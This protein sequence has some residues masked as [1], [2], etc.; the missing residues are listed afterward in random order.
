MQCNILIVDD[1][2]DIL[3]LLHSTIDTFKNDDIKIFESQS[4]EEAMLESS[5]HRVD[6]L[7][8]DYKLPGMTGV[9]LMHKIR[10]RHPEAKVIMISGETERKVRNEMLNAGA[11]AIFEKPIPLAEFLD[12]V[13][14][15]LG[16]VQTMF[17]PEKEA[18]EEKVE[19]RHVKLSDLLVNFRQDI[20][21]EAVLMLN[22]MG[23]VHA[24]TGALRDES[25][26]TAIVAV[27]M[28]I[29]NAS[30]KVARYTRQETLGSYH[31]FSGGDY[32]LL[33]TPINTM[34]AL[35]VVGKDIAAKDR[36]VENVGNMVALRDEVE[37][38]LKSIGMTG[39]TL[40]DVKKATSP[41]AGPVSASA[42]VPTMRL[43]KPAEVAP[44]PEMEALL[45]GAAEKKAP[46]PV[47]DADDFWNQ[48]AETH[49]KK[50]ANS[51]VMSLEEARKQ[52]LIPDDKK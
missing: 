29:H 24:R 48:A 7:I 47:S 4:G 51:N 12:V 18:T 31:V 27:L 36:I 30:L 23:F 2:R 38:S 8:T 33:F 5:R 25:V 10:A 21:A 42:N 32:D 15:G 1:Q 3:R 9:E 13:E 49:G 46:V 52:G 6:M 44:A 28:A 45:K 37:K 43:T 22:E 34:Y 26:E 41:A 17:A 50:P 39:D 14:R 35:L 20:N 40:L 19:E 16:L 11:L